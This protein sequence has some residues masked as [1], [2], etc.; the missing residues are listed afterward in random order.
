MKV[1]FL[2]QGKTIADQPD[3]DA[4]FRS[5]LGGADFLNIPY[6]GYAA[7][8]GWRALYKWVLMVNEEFRPDLV[9]FQFFHCLSEPGVWDCCRRLKESTN[10]PLIFA[11][12]GDPFYTGLC[13]YLA[14]PIPR[15][16]LELA[17]ES[18]A[19]FSTSMGNIADELVKNGARNI[20]FLPHAFCPQHF[21]DWEKVYDGEMEYDITMLGSRG[22]LVS[23]RPW[24]SVCNTWKRRSVVS[25]LSSRFGERFS[26]FGGGWEG[27]SAKGIVPFKDQFHIYQRSKVLIDSPAPILKTTYYASD[28]PFFMLASGVPM[29]FFHTPRFESVLKPDE[30]VYYAYNLRDA[31]DICER[32]MRLPKDVV[33]ERRKGIRKFVKARH[34]IDNRVDTIISTA[35]AIRNHRDGSIS[36]FEA[37]RA[38]R[39][40]HFRPDID[41]DAEYK[42]AVANWVG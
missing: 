28:R 42:H 8:H 22:R 40:W 17:R 9:F 26:V 3:F 21:P 1:L 19:V 38:V 12:I 30:H 29:V 18:D 33:E 6:L 23:R 34:M 24:V 20:T 4:S 11:S 2:S 39:M 10:K 14:R 36:S 7:E 41:L 35:Q 31:G 25:C 13:K 15:I 37:L 32:I 16:T 5:L 27:P